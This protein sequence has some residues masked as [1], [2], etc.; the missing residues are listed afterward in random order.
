MMPCSANRRALY[1]SLNHPRSSPRRRGVITIGAIF[2]LLRCLHRLG[3]SR[4]GADNFSEG[5]NPLRTDA[6]EIAY[7]AI[8]SPNRDG[9]ACIPVEPSAARASK[10]GGGSRAG[11]LRSTV[12]RRLHPQRLDAAHADPER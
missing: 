10:E 5:T 4:R 12:E 9:R 1:V 2:P 6:L 3:Q 11:P 7:L 8:R